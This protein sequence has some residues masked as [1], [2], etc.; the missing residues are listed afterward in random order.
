MARFVFWSAWYES[1]TPEK[2]GEELD[3]DSWNA[4]E[5]SLA[6]DLKNFLGNDQFVLDEAGLREI[7]KPRI[8]QEFLKADL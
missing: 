3:W 2:I 4:Y 1:C 7:C 8:Y 6:I 5:L